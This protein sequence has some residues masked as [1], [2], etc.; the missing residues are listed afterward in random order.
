MRESIQRRRGGAAARGAVILAG[1][2]VL[3]PVRPAA[4]EIPASVLVQAI[5]RAEGDRVRLL[6]RV[7][8]VSMR[9]VTFPSADGALLDGRGWRPCARPPVAGAKPGNEDGRADPR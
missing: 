7:P 6:V 2:I 1:L 4:H 8:L 9:D 3:A 5:A